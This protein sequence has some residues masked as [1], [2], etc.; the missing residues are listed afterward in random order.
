MVSVLGIVM[1]IVVGF[2]TLCAVA[3]TLLSLASCWGIEDYYKAQNESKE[4]VD[5]H[6]VDVP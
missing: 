3:C 1:N 6:E 4:G 2:I 5:S